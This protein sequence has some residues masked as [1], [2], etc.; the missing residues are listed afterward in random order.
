MP[1]LNTICYYA[2]YVIGEV[3]SNWNWQSVNYN[4]PITVGMMQWYGTRA[5][6]LLNR[7][8][9][10]RPTDYDMLA[11]SLKTSLT[12]NP[13]TSNYWTSR[14][15]NQ[16][17]GNSVANAFASTE[18][19]I[20]QENQAIS[21]FEGYISTLEGWG[22]SQSNPKPL[23]FAMAMYHQSPARCGDVIA[24]AGGSAT[25]DRIYQV[26][27]NNSVLG[28]YRTRYT[29]V[30]NRLKAWDGESEPPDFGQNGGAGSDGED[31]A[32]ISELANAIS[33]ITY[34]NGQL[35]VYGDEGMSDGLVCTKA[36][37]NL[38]IPS[39][40]V[41][42]TG[43]TG[44]N[45]GGGSATGS[46]AQQ[47]LVNLITSYVGQFAYSQGAGRLDPLS[48]GYTD[49]SGLCWFVYQQVTG[50][51]IG[52][53]TGAQ[54]QH[55]T[56]VGTGSGANL[57][58]NDMQLGDLVI[59]LRGSSTRHVEM[60]IGENQLCGHGGPGNGPTIKEDAQSYAA[61]NYNWNNWVVR[62]YI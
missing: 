17:E 9:S 2:M 22:M 48:S 27:L 33:Y 52:T 60:Y 26:C 35:V 46:A 19:H 13:A 16:E 54:N 38:W 39:T 62:R 11:T 6:A 5:A 44:G 43:I 23:I 57:P 40:N 59:F 4:D 24:T 31:S 14:Y 32:G 53:W 50:I 45:T 58:L 12:N 56:I 61:A 49:C 34:Y 42:G 3:E 10:E 8:Q 37:Y 47:E 1:S 21:D 25:L 36:G 29:T 28:R 30:Y 15:L 7:M 20:V 51:E 55:G 18:S 41:I